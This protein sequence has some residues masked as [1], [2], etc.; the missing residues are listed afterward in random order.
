[1]AQHTKIFGGTKMKYIEN[2]LNFDEKQTLRKAA[3]ILEYL[4]T[5]MESEK[6]DNPDNVDEDEFADTEET[7]GVLQN[8]VDYRM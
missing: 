3:E 1:M 6:E 4:C 8:F 2:R 5:E 7:Y